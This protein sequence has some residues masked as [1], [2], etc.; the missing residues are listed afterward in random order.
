M[1]A[2]HLRKRNLTRYL[3]QSNRILNLGTA[4]TFLTA[5]Q[6]YA[7]TSYSQ[8]T[9]LS[10]SLKNATLE[11]AID[12]IEEETVLS[13]VFDNMN[14]DYKIVDKQIILSRKLESIPLAQQQGRMVQGVVLDSNQEPVIGAN[15][16]V[17]GTTVGTITDIEGRFT[18][19]VP[20]NAVLVVSYIG[21]LSTE[22]VPGSKTDLTISLKEASQNLDEIVVVGYG[23]SRK[24]DL[25]G[26][27][28]VLKIDDLK[29]TPVSSVDQMM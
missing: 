14:V 11:Q 12:R 5:F 7:G 2:F 18:L 23:V 28:S 8:T 9:T 10:L 6:L 1:S 4:F 19:E 16:L 15:V 3:P 21:Y 25:T 13:R 17:K 22:L 29:D 24:K 26:A 20:N 27:V